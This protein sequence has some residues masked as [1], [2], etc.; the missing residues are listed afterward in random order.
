[1]NVFNP[2]SLPAAGCSAAAKSRREFEGCRWARR[3]RGILR[4]LEILEIG[5]GIQIKYA[6]KFSAALK[7]KRQLERRDDNGGG[8][9]GADNGRLIIRRVLK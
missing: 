5:L 6:A 1:M 8:G 9:G 7:R 4:L 3:G 2:S